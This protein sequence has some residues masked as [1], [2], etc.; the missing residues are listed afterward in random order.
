MKRKI[1]R[2]AFFCA[3]IVLFSSASFASAKEYPDWHEHKVNLDQSTIEKGYT[4]KDQNNS[5]LV[6][7]FPNV[8]HEPSEVRV[9]EI[10]NPQEF[11][12]PG[13]RISNVCVY[14]IEMEKPF[15]LDKPIIVSLE[16]KSETN[17]K[18]VVHFYDRNQKKWRPV[19]TKL[20]KMNNRARAFI[21][22]PFSYLAVFETGD[23]AV[24]TSNISGLSIGSQG[25][26]VID[27][28]TGNIIFKKNEN[29]PYQI[30]SLTKLMTAH[31]FLR[32]NN[33]LSRTT[34]I[35]AADMSP[36]SRIAFR[37][38]D[39]FTMEDL[40]YG[41]L[42]PSGNDAARAL[43]HASGLSFEEFVVEMNRNAQDMGL[44]TMHFDGVTGLESG[45][46][47]S[48]LDFAHFSKVAFNDFNI[49]KTTTAKNHCIESKNNDNRY[50]FKNTNKLLWSDL[51]IT[52]GK[53]GY[54]PPSDGG[55][56]SSLAIKAKDNDGNEVI[57]VA[58]GNSTVNGRFADVLKMT[59][60]AFS[61]YHFEK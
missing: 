41:A 35:S 1:K 10:F 32:I 26:V 2:I 6:G 22:F 29:N 47:S 11:F 57:V 61:N 50:C 36:G 53:T 17:R 40:L 58:L 20:D 55:S 44:E 30:A 3:C 13:D 48:A 27:A 7:I 56:G 42:I 43:A 52:G 39:L 15:V 45:N 21:H 54:L 9:A 18:K 4:I 12:P 38:G 31:T 60:W 51:F 24:H 33:D 49:L 37:P 8:F 25:G 5:C 46:K 28:K 23:E 19:P 16:Y 59:R 14:N 34:Q